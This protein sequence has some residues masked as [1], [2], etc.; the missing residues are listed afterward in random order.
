MLDLNKS[1]EELK[2]DV[3]ES[4]PTPKA[5]WVAA[6]IYTLLA[7]YLAQP[8]RSFSISFAAAFGA[9][10]AVIIALIVPIIASILTVRYTRF[11]NSWGVVFV[12]GWIIGEVLLVF[13]AML[14]FY[15]SARR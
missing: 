9:F 13:V 14:I 12:I 11:R 10:M 4:E 6:G 5:N 8:W 7:F 1:D 3:Q 2:N 15:Q